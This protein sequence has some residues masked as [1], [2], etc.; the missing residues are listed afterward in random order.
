ME[1][2]PIFLGLNGRPAILL[3]DGA[4]ADAKRRL[5]E[6]AGARV[7]GADDSEAR[8]AIVAL[9][10]DAAR[11]AAA[12]LKARGILVNVVDRPE[13]CDF[14]LPAIVDRAPVTI[15]IG[16]GGRSASLAKAIRQRLEAMLAPTLGGFVEALRAARPAVHARF[17][18][19][20]GRRL[21]FDA[22]LGEGGRLDPFGAPDAAAVAQ[23]LATADTPLPDRLD[24]VIVAAA[25]PDEL[26]IREARLIA[27]ADTLYHQAGIPA[28]ILNRARADATRVLCQAPP[29]APLPGRSVYLAMAGE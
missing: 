2:L 6:R 4:V 17:P 23:W 22:A 14:T 15:A 24:C 7:V 28:A 11:T 9:D 3:G 12:A 13:L 20:T 18:D 8:I 27:G 19:A 26:T 1:S 29:A 5:L 25:D 10:G 16:T 21:A